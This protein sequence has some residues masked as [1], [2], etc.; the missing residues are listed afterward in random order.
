MSSSKKEAKKEC[1]TLVERLRQF[2]AK[3]DRDLGLQARRAVAQV[4]DLVAATLGIVT[5]A[6]PLTSWNKLFAIPTIAFSVLFAVVYTLF[7]DGYQGGGIGKRIMHLRVIDGKTGEFAS[8][9]QALQRH[10]NFLSN[11][12]VFDVLYGLFS[13]GDQSIGDHIAGTLVVRTRDLE[14]VRKWIREPLR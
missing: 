2:R 11:I 4:L 12:I 7:R 1:T 9:K 13:K 3:Q 14:Q 8:Y 6:I 10:W 5:V